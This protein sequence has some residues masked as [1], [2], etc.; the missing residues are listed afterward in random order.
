MIIEHSLQL[1]LVLTSSWNT[2]EGLL[3]SYEREG[4][5]RPWKLVEK[6]IPVT[7]GVNGLAWGRGLHGLTDELG[8]IKK[9]GDGRSPTGIFDLKVSFGFVDPFDLKGLK[10]P[11]LL[12]SDDLEAIDDPLSNYY[13][14]IV[15]RSKVPCDWKSSEKMGRLQEPYKLR[16]V[17]EHNTSPIDPFCGSCIFI[18]VWSGKGKGTAGCT[19]MSEENLQRTLLWLD[20]EKKPL[21]VQLP[22]D[23]Y[24]QKKSVWHLP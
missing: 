24:N 23:I 13:N 20:P 8:P 18:H 16:I 21:L 9:E 17:V 1:I 7:V 4:V 11:Y 22:L 5:E 15:D 10:M 19:A 3:F 14:Q 6:E 12:I 2:Q